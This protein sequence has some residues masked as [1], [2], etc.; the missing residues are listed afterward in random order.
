MSVGEAGFGEAGFGEAGCTRREDIL[1]IA[2]SDI[3]KSM[4]TGA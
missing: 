3:A 4:R 2:S 1:Q